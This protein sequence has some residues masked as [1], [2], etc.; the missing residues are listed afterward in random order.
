VDNGLELNQELKPMASTGFIGFW[1]RVC[2]QGLE[3]II[4]MIPNVF[5]YRFCLKFSLEK[6]TVLPFVLFY[7]IYYAI[8]IIL[9]ITHGASIG[10][11][12]F[13]YRIVTAQGKYISWFQAIG[14]QFI[15][16]FYSILFVLSLS[17]QIVHKISVKEVHTFDGVYAVAAILTVA[18][19]VTIFLNPRKRMLHDYLVNTYVVTKGFI[20]ADSHPLPNRVS[21]F[22][23]KFSPFLLTATSWIIA[24]SFFIG[25]AMKIISIILP[26]NNDAVI[27]IGAASA[28]STLFFGFLGIGLSVYLLIIPLIPKRKAILQFGINVI[29]ISVIFLYSIFFR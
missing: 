8:V 9:T 4:F 10:K 25:L 18:N 14:R 27:N 7:V 22:L 3:L 6:S 5:I 12:A 20:P 29:A 19:I 26:N 1:K 2:A 23:Y 28:L 13:G 11:L 24:I 17:E 16:F 21:T 15:N